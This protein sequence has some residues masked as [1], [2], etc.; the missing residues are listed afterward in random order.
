MPR[1]VVL[2]HTPCYQVT[3]DS[4]LAPT[5]H[6]RPL[7]SATH[8]RSA[9][10]PT[11]PSAVSPRQRGAYRECVARQT[12]LLQH[13]VLGRVVNGLVVSVRRARTGHVVPL[14]E[15]GRMGMHCTRPSLTPRNDALPQTSWRRVPQRTIPRRVQR[16]WWET[17]MEGACGSTVT[18]GMMR[19]GGRATMTRTKT[20]GE[21][22]EAWCVWNAADPAQPSQ[23]DLQGAQEAGVAGPRLSPSL[24]NLRAAGGHGW[25]ADGGGC[26]AGH[27]QEEASLQARDRGAA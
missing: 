1:S 17:V 13:R 14:R 3:R 18:G 22:D 20:V 25:R 10:N 4:P 16:R 15:Q 11:L 24:S 2:N 19:C 9:A 26:G 27:R 23:Q 7:L 12:L 5:H 8:A 21:Q 6:A